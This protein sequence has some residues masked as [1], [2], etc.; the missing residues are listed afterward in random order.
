MNEPSGQVS[1]GTGAAGAAGETACASPWTGAL[2]AWACQAGARMMRATAVAS[3]RR[4]GRM[5]L[6]DVTGS[7]LFVRKAAHLAESPNPPHDGTS[8][9]ARPLEACGADRRTG[10]RSLHRRI[11]RAGDARAAR[12]PRR[13]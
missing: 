10:S 8:P 1:A 3:R 4:L 13:G 6:R 7:V 9:I 11:S 2:W 5:L 12:S